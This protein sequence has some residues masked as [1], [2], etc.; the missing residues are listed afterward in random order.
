MA[1]PHS[2]Q[3]VDTSVTAP[4]VAVVVLAVFAA[5]LMVDLVPRFHLG[6]SV[7]FMVTRLGGFIP[8]N[9]SWLYGLALGWLERATGALNA[10]ALAQIVLSWAAI[11]AF[12]A[13]AASALNLPRPWAALMLVVCA[14]E[15]L[16][17]F[18]S[19]SFMADSAAQSVFVLLCAVLLT[20][21][22][23]V[24]RF[25]LVFAIGFLLIALRVLYFPALAVGLVAA[26]AWQ[27]WRCRR[28]GL[29]GAAADP[30]LRRWAISA[31]A[32]VTANFAYAGANM[33]MTSA[34]SLSTNVGGMAFLV[35]A[36]RPS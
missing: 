31:L 5:S 16:T 27:A 10:V 13:A 36:F 26:T 19:R 9:R 34:R 6:D 28:L 24:A 4:I 14:L 11:A 7:T 25:A 15:P 2:P 32:I 30:D 17:Y 23:G 20:R 35:A 12:T 33:E 21:T 1:A 22:G 3:R 8:D 18:W 29:R